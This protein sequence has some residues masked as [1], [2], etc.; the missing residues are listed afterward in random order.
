MITSLTTPSHPLHPTLSNPDASSAASRSLARI[1]PRFRTL[2]VK[3]FEELVQ[4][5]GEDSTL[6]ALPSRSSARSKNPRVPTN[7][8][9]NDRAG[10]AFSTTSA[11]HIVRQVAM[12][13]DGEETMNQ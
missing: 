7:A 3:D 5:R 1:L 13:E 6:P 4:A 11:T 9:P 8:G 12:L 10:R 2:I